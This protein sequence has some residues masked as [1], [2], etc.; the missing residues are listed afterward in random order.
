MEQLENES[1]EILLEVSRGFDNLLSDL[2]SETGDTEGDLL[3]KSLALMAI[4]MQA[5]RQGNTVGFR[6]PDDHFT[7]ITGL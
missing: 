3:V 5:K 6:T 7:E 1:I 2:T 4:A